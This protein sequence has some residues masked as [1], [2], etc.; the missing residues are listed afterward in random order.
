MEKSFSQ[1]EKENPFIINWPS[2]FDPVKTKFYAHNEI[3]IN[4]RPEKVWTILIDVLKW[5]KWYKGAKD[6]VL[7]NPNDTFLTSS[8]V[9]S[10]ETMGLNFVT[11]IKKFEPYNHLEWESENNN[12][13]TYQAWLIIPTKN[14]CKVITD[15]THNG[16]R[17]LSEK[18]YH[19]RKLERLHEV[20]LK[21]LK[22]KSES[23]DN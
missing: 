20:W 5:P 21:E 9:F 19:R 6:V 3:E 8:T 1:Q 11:T 17:S 13:T 14:G 23:M 10:W 22:N 2:E 12:I 16:Y 15:E 4:A 7:M 18:K